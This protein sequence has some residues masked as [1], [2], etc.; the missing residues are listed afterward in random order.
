M[1][2]KV[3]E[4]LTAEEIESGFKNVIKDGL[5]SQT[6][7]TFT[8]GVFLVAFALQLGASNTFI[9]LLAALP[10]LLQLV[11]IPSIYL[12]EKVR[13]RRAIS[14]YTSLVSRTF[15]LFIALIPYLFHGR[16]R[17]HF[18]ILALILQSSFAAVSTCSW[19]SWMRDLVPQDRLG[20]FFSKRMSFSI[21]VSLPLYLATGFFIDRW[22]MLFPHYEIYSYSI[23][24][25]LGFLT[26]MI[27]VYFISTIPEPKMS[28]SKERQNL[29]RLIGQPFK[30]GNFKSLILFLGS[31]NF[32]VN[33]AAP[34]FTVYMLKRLELDMT[35][36]IIL[37]I[38]SQAMNFI[39]LHVWGKYTDRFSNKS[40]LGVCGPLFIICILLWTFTTL[41]EK[42][43]LSIPLLFAI[44]VFTGISTA[45]VSLASGNIG[46][47]LAPKVSA[48]PYLAAI[49]FVNSLGAGI[50]PIFGGKFADFFTERELTWTL[51]WTG[52]KGTMTFPTLNLRQWDFFF[53]FAFLIGLY[54]IHRLAKVKEVG[55][56]E[57]KVIIHELISEARKIM[58]NFSSVGGLCHAIHFPFSLITVRKR[59]K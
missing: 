4:S 13:V 36:I 44:H 2:F 30:D 11:Q 9:G 27:G 34:F 43:V 16:E 14:V 17:L 51:M 6:M 18:L 15:W 46:L 26:G 8:S 56:V 28:S 48:T 38:T 25:F 7:V 53:L 29:F 32:A 10:P 1:K 31:W 47:K 57:E 35:L 21:A 55:E 41:P 23:L 37:T 50:A 42:H 3:T 33:L 49:G 12:I 24:F 52:P 5:A 22:Q 54:S 45:G 40:V 39:F 58:R 20:V 19:N 59:D